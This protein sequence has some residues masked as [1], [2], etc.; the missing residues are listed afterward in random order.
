MTDELPRRF[1]GA[2]VLQALLLKSGTL[3]D[4]EDVAGAFLEAVKNNAPA[5]LVINALWEDEPTFESP[6][7]A[8]KLFSNPLGLYEL[9]AGG[10]GGP[11]RALR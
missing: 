11:R 7:D 3:A 4:V 5:Q 8:R 9:I 6:D 10:G 2:S 1:E